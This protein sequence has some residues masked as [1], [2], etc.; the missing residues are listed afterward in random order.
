[1]DN[2]PVGVRNSFVLTTAVVGPLVVCTA[3]RLTV[4]IQRNDLHKKTA[5]Q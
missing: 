2:T 5:V 4:N 1:M 3:P